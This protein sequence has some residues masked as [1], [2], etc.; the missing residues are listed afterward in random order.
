MTELVM[1]LGRVGQLGGREGQKLDHAV[2]RKQWEDE[3]SFLGAGGGV[4]GRKRV[5]W[6]RGLGEWVSH[7]H[8]CG[9]HVASGSSSAPGR[10]QQV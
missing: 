3:A 8:D 4:G 9:S 10:P 2:P 1:D 5:R 6:G 7:E